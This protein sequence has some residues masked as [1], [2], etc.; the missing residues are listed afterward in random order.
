MIGDTIGQYRIIERLGEGGMG[1]VY[2]AE[3]LKLRRKAAVKIIAPHLTRDA[4]RRQRFIQEALLAASIDHPHIAAI[5]DVDQAGDRTYIAMEYVRGET[6]RQK[7]RAGPF[8][9][10][11]AI[12][13]SIEVA[14]ALAKVHERGIIHRDLKPENVTV[15][16]DGYAKVIDFGLAKL[17]E[18]ATHGDLSQGLTMADAQVQTADGMV[19]GTVAYMSPEQ[20]RGETVDARSDIFAFGVLLHELLTGAAPFRRKSA[21]E[22]LSAI[23]TDAAPPLRVDEAAIASDLQRI[24]RKCLMKDPAS[25]YQ[26]MRDLVVDLRDV[27]EG[28]TSTRS[29][30][31]PAARPMARSRVMTGAGIAVVVVGLAGALWWAVERRTTTAPPPAAAPSGRPVVAVMNFENLAATPD[32]AWLS[33]GLPSMIVTGLAQTPDLEVVST[34]RLADAAKELGKDTLDAVDRSWYARVAQKAGA[35]VLVSGSIVRGGNDYRIDARVE[36]VI[37]GRVVFAGSV[38]GA[39]VLSLADDLSA[40][41]RQGLDVR[42]T[43]EVHRVA[44]VSSSSVEAYRLYTEGLEAYNN[45]RFDDGRKLFEQAVAIDPAF[46]LAHNN[47]AAMAALEGDAELQRKHLGHAVEHLDRLS[48]RDAGLVRA[49]VSAMDGRF[50]ESVRQY[51]AVLNR[52]PDTEDAY[53]GLSF[54]YETLIGAVPDADKGLAALSRGVQRLP[55]SPGLQN[56]HGYAQLEA[57]HID[58]AIATFQN[59]MRLR[60]NEANAPDSL[61]DAYLFAGNTDKAIEYFT[62]AFDA[63]RAGS[64]SGRAWSYAVIGQYDR[65]LEDF[66]PSFTKAFALSRVG[67]LKD[68]AATLQEVR[69][70]IDTRRN[71]EGAAAAVLL[72]ADLALDRGDCA[73]TLREIEAARAVVSPA[74]RWIARRW[75]VL[76]D[77]LGGVCEARSGRLD[78]ARA[79]L[80]RIKRDHLPASP[81]ERWWVSALEGEIALADHKA[82]EAA[83]VFASGEPPGKMPI[84]RVSIGTPLSVFGNNLVIRDGR[85]RALAAQGRDA[86]A[87]Q[88]YR[89]LLAPSRTSKW[90]AMLEPRYVF[91]LATLLD[92]T[93]QRE[94]ARVEYQRF[95]DLWKNA[96]S[97]LPEIT[98]ARRRA[99]S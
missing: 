50:D 61:A 37:A 2:L 73:T 87:I 51:E 20:A 93:G 94:A 55:S 36:D 34:Q 66:S 30:E 13:V 29:V 97:G 40:R 72:G 59:Y 98:A 64:R 35:R 95:L 53:A 56:L 81:S 8:K 85:A 23:L 16:E 69:G 33:K 26:T 32:I 18:P 21:A 58:E 11:R 67:R 62:R 24:V 92:K 68:A 22:T 28:L 9:A 99:A 88:L 10:R 78:R 60:P 57:G 82:A 74:A 45:A 4:G 3:D 70:H 54:L 91:A 15:S 47:L 76:A 19:L 71:R 83:A 5:Y 77:H 79:R 1:E 49:S 96:D 7:L 27:R 63:G 84:T 17:T 65:A 38:R 31:I 12:E 44:D 90:T 89:D 46:S 25:R 43:A 86:E 52:Y 48:E 14:D 39:D 80:D 6:L 75:L 42:T 41:I